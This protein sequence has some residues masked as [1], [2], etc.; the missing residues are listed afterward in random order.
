MTKKKCKHE[1]LA[2][3]LDKKLKKLSKK[4]GISV[5]ELIRKS[6]EMYAIKPTDVEKSIKKVLPL[7]VS[8][9][10]LEEDEAPVKAKTPAKKKTPSSSK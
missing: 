7:K 4:T 2:K 5:E 8:I 6:L 3:E 9:P 1:K 10:V